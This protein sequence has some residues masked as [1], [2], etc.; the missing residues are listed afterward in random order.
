MNKEFLHTLRR[1]LTADSRGKP[2]DS[3]LCPT[4]RRARFSRLALF[5]PRE[6]ATT[7]WLHAG[8]TDCPRLRSVRQ[9]ISNVRESPSEKTVPSATIGSP[10]LICQTNQPI[11]RCISSV[12]PSVCLP[13]CLTICLST[14]LSV[15]RRQIHRQKN[16][17]QRL[18]SHKSSVCNDKSKIAAYKVH[19]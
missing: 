15:V 7:S 17:E 3:S 9:R 19:P 2:P 8:Y 6:W 10:R 1:F 14:S 16:R 5:L 12:R 18:P 4:V 11:D 13:V